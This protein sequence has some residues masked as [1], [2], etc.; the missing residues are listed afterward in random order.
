VTLIVA[1]RFIIIEQSVC[2]S[3]RV[4]QNH[5]HLQNSVTREQL[6]AKTKEK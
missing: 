3:Y 5:K 1:I 2:P 4:F 6:N